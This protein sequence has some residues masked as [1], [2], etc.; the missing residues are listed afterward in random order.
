MKQIISPGLMH[1]TG[2][3]V[4]ETGCPVHKTGMTLWD[5]MGREMGGAF[6]MWDTYTP[7]A[8]SCQC[9]AKTTTILQSN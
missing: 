9:M 4:H 7:M 8:D 6:R 2:C 5:G 3:P 1:E